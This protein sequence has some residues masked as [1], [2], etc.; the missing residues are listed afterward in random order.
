MITLYADPYDDK[1]GDRWHFN[2]PW[3]GTIATVEIRTE[4]IGDYDHFFQWIFQQIPSRKAVT[5]RIK[6]T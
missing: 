1:R 6:F 4:T 3:Q 5:Q 2:S